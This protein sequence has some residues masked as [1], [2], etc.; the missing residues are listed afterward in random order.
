MQL[1]GS[2]G[3]LRLGNGKKGV[4]GIDYEKI[5]DIKNRLR[6][7][8]QKNE[9]VLKNINISRDRL[10]I[11]SKNNKI[12][13]SIDELTDCYKKV[14]AMQAKLDKTINKI[15]KMVR[16]F[17]DTDA[18]CAAGFRAIMKNKTVLDM[19]N[20][21]DYDIAVGKI[22]ALE[23]VSKGLW[24]YGETELDGFWDFIDSIIS[25]RLIGN[26]KIIDIINENNQNMNVITNE[27]WSELEKAKIK[28]FKYAT[29]DWNIRGFENA[30]IESINGVITPFFA[31]SNLNNP[32]NVPKIEIPLDE[33]PNAGDKNNIKY[34]VGN[35]EG[36]ISAQLLV[37]L[38]SIGIGSAGKAIS[39][40]LK[41]ES[42]D[43]IPVI[44]EVSEMASNV[45]ELSSIINDSTTIDDA[46]LQIKNSSIESYDSE[47]IT[48]LLKDIDET[49]FKTRGKANLKSE[50]LRKYGFPNFDKNGSLA[51]VLAFKNMDIEVI[52][53]KNPITLYRRGYPG[54]TTSP[55]GLGKWWSDKSLTIEQV[56]D[57]LAVCENW[58]NPLTGEYKITIPAGT[59]V[60]RGIAE[61]QIIKNSAGEI[62]ESRAGG[63][64]QYW[65]NDIDSSWLN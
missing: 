42:L 21:L 2:D 52:E 15:D 50:I 30:F 59:K 49:K 27:E 39:G 33:Q 13:N 26:R 16:A 24:K 63:A 1:S 36:T 10:K 46:I 22:E 29:T 62:I 43:E 44:G 25:G 57:K 48:K 41:L 38:A 14:S 5:A 4:V 7:C 9:I 40:A 35:I 37:Y 56:R 34:I 58:G 3:A 51:D 47:S 18:K 64:T 55:Y 53:L 28:A 60:I 6:R 45:E 32:G 65:L 11:C 54:E 19:S 8:Y 12:R 23:K 61:K 31:L 17:K 20:N